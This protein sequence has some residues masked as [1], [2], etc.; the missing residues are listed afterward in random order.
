MTDWLR[1]KI[2][3]ILFTILGKVKTWLGIF[4]SKRGYQ[5][6]ANKPQQRKGWV[7]STVFFSL[8]DITFFFGGRIFTTNSSSKLFLYSTIP[9]KKDQGD[10]QSYKCRK[11]T[12]TKTQHSNMHRLQHI[13]KWSGHQKE[14]KLCQ[15]FLIYF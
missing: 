14:N 4:Q 13:N 12:Q 11:C 7:S 6:G 8:H 3:P 2:F 9:Q 15:K 5:R 10:L 1:W